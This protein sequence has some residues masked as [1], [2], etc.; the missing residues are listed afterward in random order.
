[1]SALQ[2]LLEAAAKRREQQAKDNPPV[3]TVLS[4]SITNLHNASLYTD[5][6]KGITYNERQSLAISTARSGKSFVLIGAAGTGKTTSMKGSLTALIQSGLVPKYENDGHK[7]LQ[8]ATHGIIICAYTRRAVANIKRNLSHDMAG[9]CIT[10][11]AALEFQPEYFTVL[12][13]ASGELKNSM[14]FVPTRSAARPLPDCIKYCVIEESSMLGTELFKQLQEALPSDCKYIFLGDIQQLPPVFGPAILGF[15]MLELPVIE[16]TEVYRQA[17]ESPIISLAHRILSGKRMELPELMEWT[18]KYKEKG[19][20]FHP[21]KKK[22]HP[23]HLLPRIAA[24]FKK[25]LDSGEFDPETDMILLPFNK[26][27]GTIEL[28]NEIA[29]YLT[30]KRGAMT[31]EIISGFNKLYFAPGD[32]IL[33]EKEDAEILEIRRNLPYAGVKQPRPASLTLDRWGYDLAKPKDVEGEIGSDDFDLDNVD[34]ILNAL[35]SSDPNLDK[36]R[37]NEASHIITIRMKDTGEEISISKSAEINQ[38]LLGYCLTVHKSQGSEWKKVY[39]VF[40]QSHNTMIQR[41]LLYTAVT[42]AREDLYVICEPDTFVKGIER[43]KVPGN[44]WQEKAIYFQG[45]VERG[46]D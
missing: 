12:D 2:R 21:L 24:F 5:A 32:K 28:N 23:E 9:S 22:L 37:K 26:G 29:E 3:K 8:N 34:A 4:D 42:R 44:T 33:Y 39:C 7:H 45:K 6:E 46:E 35:T 15:K 10:V 43:Q 27:L 38:L 1:M 41:E 40:H 25:R 17:L 19:L 14:R 11:H 30:K 31:Y 16:L 36:E 20:Q 13:E 18:E